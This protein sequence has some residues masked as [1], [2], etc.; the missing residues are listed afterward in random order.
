MTKLGL[1]AK[2]YSNSGTYGTPVYGELT[3][4]RDL[5]LSDAL[6]E[7]DVT[8]RASNGWR[9]TVG[10]LREIS[11]EFEMVNIAGDSQIASIRSAYNTRT[12]VEYTIVDGDLTVPGTARGVRALFVVTKC[13]LTQELENA[14]MWSVTLKPTPATNPPVQI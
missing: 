4:I 5:T 6:A 1:T 8:R 10:T 13:E 7:A 11:V 9:E 2:M 3:N 12:P 14:Q